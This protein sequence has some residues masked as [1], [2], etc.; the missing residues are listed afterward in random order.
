[1]L[2]CRLLIFFRISFF[3]KLVQD[4]PSV[5]NSLDQDQAQHFV[6][7]DTRV[8]TVCKNYQQTTFSSLSGTK[9]FSHLIL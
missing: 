6:G 3:E 9:S 8:Q 5:S 1:M 4:Y 7:P 2:F